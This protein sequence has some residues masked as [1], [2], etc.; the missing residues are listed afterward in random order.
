MSVAFTWNR[1]AMRWSRAA[2]MPMRSCRL[3]VGWP[4]SIPAKGDEESISE[5]E[6]SAECSRTLRYAERVIMPSRRRRR[7]VGSP[8]GSG[9]R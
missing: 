4:T 7:P 2:N 9:E 1:A 8:G 6:S 5:F 3:S